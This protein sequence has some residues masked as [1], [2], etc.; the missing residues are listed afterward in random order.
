MFSGDMINSLRLITDL[1]KMIQLIKK[2]L[3]GTM[4]LDKN[5]IQSRLRNIRIHNIHVKVYLDQSVCDMYDNNFNFLSSKFLNFSD[6]NRAA[7]NC[8]NI[9]NDEQIN[10]NM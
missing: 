5:F 4:H 3:T 7:K 6:K 1:H 10:S 8:R 9:D 2:L